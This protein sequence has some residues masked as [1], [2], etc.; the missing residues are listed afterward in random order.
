L[1]E[2]PVVA[3]SEA[4]EVASTGFDFGAGEECT[5]EFDGCEAEV[6]LV[7]VVLGEDGDRDGW[8]EPYCAVLGLQ[9]ARQQLDES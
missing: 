6:E 2:R 3:E 5:E 4:A 1:D 7:D 8:V 9:V